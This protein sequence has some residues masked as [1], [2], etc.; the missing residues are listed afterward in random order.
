MAAAHFTKTPCEPNTVYKVQRKLYFSNICFCA[1]D[2]VYARFESFRT[3]LYVFMNIV[4][5]HVQRIMGKCTS[6]HLFFLRRFIPH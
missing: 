6:R 4:K 5:V 2:I 3:F 1:N